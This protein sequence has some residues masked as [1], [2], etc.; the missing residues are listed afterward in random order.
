MFIEH[1]KEFINTLDES[2]RR[3]YLGIRAIEIGHKG[4]TAVARFFGFNR[5]TVSVGVT[6]VKELDYPDKGRVRRKGGGRTRIIDKYPD[7]VSEIQSVIQN[8]TAGLPQDENVYWVTISKP[9][10]RQKLIDKCIEV[11]EYII[12]QVLDMLGFRKRSFV[13]SLTAA[14]VENRDEQFQNI[15][16]TR[17]KCVEAGI[18][19]ISI[20]TKKKELIGNFKR[21]GTVM[22]TG[23]PKALD[24]DFANFADGKIVPHGIYD[25]QKN[26]GYITIG[27]SHDTSKF[28]CDN[29]ENVW[30]THLIHEYPD[31]GTIVVLC[32]GGGSN[33]S[34]HH[35]VKQ[36][37]MNLAN[38]IGKNIFVMHYPPY[39]SKHNPIEHRLFSQITRSWSG[40]P[41]S[42]VQN[43]ISRAQNTTTSTGLKV[44]VSLNQEIYDIKRPLDFDF[45]SRFKKQVIARDV[46]PKWNYLIM[47]S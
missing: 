19:I 35:I 28:V 32:D 5:K 44:F 45:E 7:L 12:S 42:S 21:Q 29:I 46:L 6:E 38:R 40:E 20:D 4:I 33:A 31:A 39:C 1:E 15:A 25:V 10:I 30:N 8:H 47:P 11:S 14:E 26:V 9:Q 24:H 37:F 17:Q 41:L 36:D 22:S 34:S 23:Q 3:H 27:Q 2:Q 13:K 43:A 18:P 16:E